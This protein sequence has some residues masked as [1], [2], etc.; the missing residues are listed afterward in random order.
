MILNE[1]HQAVQTAM[2]RPTMIVG[3][4]GNTL[5]LCETFTDKELFW[6]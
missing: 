1:K 4:S 3:N 2:Y 5:Q 6:F